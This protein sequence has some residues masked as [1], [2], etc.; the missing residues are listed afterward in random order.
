MSLHRCHLSQGNALC[1]EEAF[2]MFKEQVNRYQP[3]QQSS[4]ILA[5]MGS[6]TTFLNPSFCLLL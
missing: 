5:Q 4:L 6:H 1:P 3:H 2:S